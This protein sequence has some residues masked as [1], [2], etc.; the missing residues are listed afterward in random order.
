MKKYVYL[1]VAA[2]IAST[3]FVSCDSKEEKKE[4]KNEEKTE[5]NKENEE[6]Q[7]PPKLDYAADFNAIRDAIV[8][9]DKATLE[10]YIAGDVDV[11]NMFEL[12]DGGPEFLALLKKST[13]KDLEPTN[14]DGVEGLVLNLYLDYTDPETNEK[15]ESAIMLYFNEGPDKL[16]L[17]YL[18]AAG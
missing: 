5:V 4:E 11:D 9:K 3:T 16:E 18:L 1:T 7:A 17:T 6:D 2:V 15:Y 13:Y 8:K 14:A 10:Q 12:F